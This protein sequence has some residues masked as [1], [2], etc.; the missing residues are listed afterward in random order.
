MGR[1]SSPSFKSIADR[2]ERQGLRADGFDVPHTTISVN[3]FKGGTAGNIVPDTAEF[4]FEF[5]Y[6]P[7]FDPDALIAEIAGFAERELLPRMRAVDAAAD[8]LRARE[9]HPGARAT[10]AIRS[11][12]ACGTS[13]R[14]SGGEG[15]LRHGSRVLPE[16]GVPAMVCGPG[17]IDQAHKP[18]E[19]VT[20]EQLALCDRFIRLVA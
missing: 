13:L 7:G 19:F 1:A 5:R 15:L 4:S 8:C 9:R 16:G 17:S 2:E 12:P 14:R 20:L 18:D 3:L 6:V 11:F 10:K